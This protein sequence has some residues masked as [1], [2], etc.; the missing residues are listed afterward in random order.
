MDAVGV[1]GELSVAERRVWE[2]FPT[3]QL[4]D[5]GTGNATDEDPAG[6]D[7]WS[8]HRQVRAEVL[9]ALLCGA[10][11]EKPG[12][13]G[14]VWLRCARV[15][16]LIDLQDAEV[17]HSLRLEKCHVS[18]GA[19]LADVTAR[20]MV[21]L[22]C[23]L[24]PVSLLGAS[25][26]G[27]LGF[28]GSQL[29]NANGPV[30]GADGLTVTG[31]M[32]CDGGFRA[33][34]EIRLPGASIGRLS[35]RGAQLTSGNGQ[36][37]IANGLTVAGDMFCDKG[38]SAD[39][40]IRLRG[41]RIGGR[42]SFSGAQLASESGPAL[43]ADALTVGGAMFCDA[44]FRADGEIHLL[45]A[46]IGDD[47]IFSCAQLAS[48]SGPALTADGLTV[49]GAM[50]CGD[51]FRADGEI[52]LRNATIGVLADDK[53]SWPARLELDGLT[54]GDMR[55]YL[56]APER[57]KWL[58]RSAGYHGQPFEQLA[59][60]YRRQGRDEQARRVLLAQQRART[61]KRPCR[62]RWWGWL[63]D[64]LVG[65][66]YAPGRALALLAAA[67]AAGWVFFR[68]HQPPPVQPGAHP[69][70]NAAIYTL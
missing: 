68:A 1:P 24:G 7:G 61:R 53:A 12:H 48:E 64:A 34:G 8:P 28:S 37:L 43:T 3:G 26:T 27:R 25:I 65:Y 36:A 5:F 70:F 33:D 47:L 30:L 58:G 29:N 15:T 13:V 14:R 52:L 56:P 41:A 10:I 51:G 59:A 42:L 19:D 18:D 4:V 16:G 49:G 21:L 63:Q 31:G 55:L 46:S 67:L 35:F 66:G 2:A 20:T 50:F 40:E 44:G 54:Y 69:S 6:G 45:N 11:S 23:Q 62:G 9:A 60:Y 32:F 57:L 17:R 39:G 22:G 38:F